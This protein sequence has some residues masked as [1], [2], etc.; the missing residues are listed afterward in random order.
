MQAVIGIIF[1]QNLKCN[2]SSIPSPLNVKEKIE[3]NDVDIRNV[4]MKYQNKKENILSAMQ[5]A[6]IQNLKLCQVGGENS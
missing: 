1:D 3:D 4:L 6:V 2:F 5:R